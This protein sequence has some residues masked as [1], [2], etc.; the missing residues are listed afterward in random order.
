MTVYHQ[1][2]LRHDLASSGL[3]KAS[4]QYLGPQPPPQSSRKPQASS[5]MALGCQGPSVVAWNFQRLQLLRPWKALDHAQVL[6]RC[7][8]LAEFHRKSHVQDWPIKGKENG[9]KKTDTGWEI[10]ENKIEVLRC[11][12]HRSF[13]EHDHTVGTLWDTEQINKWRSRV[14]NGTV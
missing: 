7:L 1:N 10:T 3:Q 8:P 5:G 2:E 13:N 6:R 14:Q 12:S 4:G 9:Q 11:R